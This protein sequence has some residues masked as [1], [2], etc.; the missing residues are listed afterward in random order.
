MIVRYM[1]LLRYMNSST[2]ESVSVEVEVTHMSVNV[3]GNVE[4]CLLRRIC[5][6][7]GLLSMGLL[8][9]PNSVS[10]LLLP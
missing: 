9:S 3:F 6:D 8:C 1:V 4:M 7:G 2:P 5:H 10:I